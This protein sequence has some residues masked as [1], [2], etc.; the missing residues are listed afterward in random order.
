[1]NF[2]TTRSEYASVKHNVPHDMA[3]HLTPPMRAFML[4]C[5]VNL[6]TG[7]YQGQMVLFGQN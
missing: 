7:E 3:N 1:M 6:Y 4:A 5:L 2:F